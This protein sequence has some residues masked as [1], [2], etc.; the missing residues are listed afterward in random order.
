MIEMGFWTVSIEYKKSKPYP[1]L[2][3]FWSFLWK[4]IP[5]KTLYWIVLSFMAL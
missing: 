1:F 5:I 3:I 2:K 4:R